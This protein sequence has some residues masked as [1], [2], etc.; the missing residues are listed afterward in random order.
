M[1]DQRDF[2]AAGSIHVNQTLPD[3][4]LRDSVERHGSAQRRQPT[5]RDTHPSRTRVASGTVSSPWGRASRQSTVPAGVAVNGSYIYW[6]DNGIGQ[7]WEAN[8]DGTNPV[9]EGSIDG[10]AGTFVIDTGNRGSLELHA[11]FVAAHELLVVNFIS[12]GQQDVAHMPAW[13]ED[14]ATVPARVEFE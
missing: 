12:L 3:R 6:A 11:P 9:V 8:L 1:V 7:I 13:F 5:S 4:R 10:I 2:R 14:A